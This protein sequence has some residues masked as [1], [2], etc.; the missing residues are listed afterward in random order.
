MTGGLT[1]FFDLQQPPENL[2]QLMMR[3]FEMGA[4]FGCS[5]EA[6][7]HI[8]E[9][10]LP[11]G[12]VKGHAYSITGMRVVDTP[13][14]KVPLLRVRN[15]WGNDQEWNGAWSDNSRVRFRFLNRFF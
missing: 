8:W 4:L 13:H 10:K 2:M 12:L 7:P 1:E 3:G 14:G 15:P 11:T 9:A 5:I 6:D